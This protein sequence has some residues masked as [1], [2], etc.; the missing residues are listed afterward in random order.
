MLQLSAFGPKSFACP[1]YYSPALDKSDAKHRAITTLVI[2]R[3]KAHAS[4]TEPQTLTLQ[5]WPCKHRVGGWVGEGGVYAQWRSSQMGRPHCGTFIQKWPNR[6]IF[7]RGHWWVRAQKQKH[8]AA[9][10]HVRHISQ[11]FHSANSHPA[12]RMSICNASAQLRAT[13]ALSR[14]AVGG[15]QLRPDCTGGLGGRREK[16]PPK[17]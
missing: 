15:G 7:T 3:Q 10:L 16:G 2:H 12:W 5:P 4:L 9:S 6:G 8:R 14:T 17:V 11:H 13:S 1:P